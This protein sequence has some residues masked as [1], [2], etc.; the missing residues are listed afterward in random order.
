M[1]LTWIKKRTQRMDFINDQTEKYRLEKSGHVVLDKSGP[2]PV[3]KLTKKGE[4]LLD[5]L[6]SKLLHEYAGKSSDN[7]KTD[8]RKLEWS[9]MIKQY[10]ELWPK[11]K[12]SNSSGY[13]RCNENELFERFLWF[14]GEYPEYTWTDVMDAANKY[15]AP[16]NISMEFTYLQSAKYFIKREDKNKTITSNLADVIYNIKSGNEHEVETGH[17]YFE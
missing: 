14:F 11:G 10:N 6:E 15:V 16:F 3:Y 8:V 4:D 12:R 5:S 2:M 1:V 17:F 7:P 13:Y 9:P